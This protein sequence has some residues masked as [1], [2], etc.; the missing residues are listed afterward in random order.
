[1]NKI[2]S[3][4]RK[5]V[6]TTITAIGLTVLLTLLVAGYELFSS[7]QNFQSGMN[8]LDFASFANADLT[9]YCLVLIFA[10]LLLLPFA[11]LFY[12]KNSIN[13]KDEIFDKATLGKDILLGVILAIISGGV[14]LYHFIVIE[15]QSELAF[16]G[17]GRLSATEIILM[18]I[19]LVFVSGI[20]KEI[21]FRGLAKNFCSDTLGETK[22]L[23]LFNVFFALLDWFNVGQSFLLGLIWI[24]G[25]KKS[26]H[27]IV[28]MI[29]HGG[30]NLL[31]ILFY[32]FT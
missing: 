16:S 29:A 24:F 10:N 31:S 4:N 2:K 14:C 9:T 13:L 27:L 21:F 8:P 25:Y 28:P 6:K 19:S 32:A 17:W 22:A 5:A 30:V 1:M 18:V 26:K 11:V 12:K 7:C 15:G 23:L 20:S 3:E